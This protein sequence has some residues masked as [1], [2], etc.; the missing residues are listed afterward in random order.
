MRVLCFAHRLEASRFFELEAFES[1]NSHTYKGQSFYLLLTGEGMQAATECLTE[2]L[3]RNNDITQVLN[4]GVA[5]G[6]PACTKL[7]EIY[8]VRSFYRQKSDTEIEFTSFTSKAQRAKLDL[9]SVESRVQD[10]E[11]ATKLFSFAAMIDREAWALA[12]ACKRFQKDFYS[13]KYISDD[14]T[15]EACTQIKDIAEEISAALV[16]AYKDFLP[17]S[18]SKPSDIATPLG[19]HFTFTQKAEWQK[20]VQKIALKERLSTL[21]VIASLP[22]FQAVKPKDSTKLLLSYLQERLDPFTFN[23]KKRIESELQP[24]NKKD[25]KVIYDRTLET[26]NIDIYLQI[27]SPKD[28]EQTIST[29]QQLPLEKISRLLRGENVD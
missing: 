13:F 25:F 18:V 5:A 15:R 26:D 3:A 21:E 11:S 20:M 28:I 22:Q 12:S 6:N 17:A 10:K 27:K 16:L 23:I 24:F 2:F 29:L 1:L 9:I 7:G 19:Y 14:A 8:Q 4:F